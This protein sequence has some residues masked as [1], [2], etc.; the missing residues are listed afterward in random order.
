MQWSLS[1]LFLAAPDIHCFS[2][3]PHAIKHKHADK[4]RIS[5]TSL[6]HHMPWNEYVSSTCES[7][8]DVH[9]KI[10]YLP[11]IPEQCSIHETSSFCGEQ[12]GLASHDCKK[13]PLQGK[14]IQAVLFATSIFQ[15]PIITY[16]SEHQHWY[17]ATLNIFS[18][19]FTVQRRRAHIRMAINIKHLE[20][21][22][23]KRTLINQ[24]LK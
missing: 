19:N 16:I 4:H 21:K 9:L 24:F 7:I 23:I 10:F 22:K 18:R 20:K 8:V 2:A 5:T 3:T 12:F 11:S 17:F 14:M 1:V 13:W 6:P 15:P